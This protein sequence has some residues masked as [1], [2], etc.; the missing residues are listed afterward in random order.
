MLKSIQA[1]KLDL[2]TS[3]VVRLLLRVLL[4]PP[5]SW[6]CGKKVQ[7]NIYLPGVLTRPAEKSFQILQLPSPLKWS[8]DIYPSFHS[9]SVQFFLFTLLFFIR[10]LI[11]SLWCGQWWGIFLLLLLC[12]CLQFE[13]EL[14][15]HCSCGGGALP[16]M[17]YSREGSCQQL[18][19]R[20]TVTSQTLPL[21]LIG[22][23]DSGAVDS[24]SSSNSHGVELQSEDFYRAE[25][26]LIALSDN[27]DNFSKHDKK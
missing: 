26:Y 4:L 25:L 1:N 19:T 8:S 16:S 24:C 17:C 14:V 13:L 3:N 9:R 18:C 22:C 20:I 21:A 15:L 5:P 6:S 23:T 7:W 2:P 12:H 10:L 11:S 27:N